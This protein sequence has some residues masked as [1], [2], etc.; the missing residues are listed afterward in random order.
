MKTW[1]H[2]NGVERSSTGAQTK[3][4]TE[5]GRRFCISQNTA[6]PKFTS[7][8]MRRIR[9]SRG[10]HILLLYLGDVVYSWTIPSE[11]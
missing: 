6:R 7:C 10:Q 11:A 1:P 5:R 2:S 9:Q 8:F 4:V 3:L